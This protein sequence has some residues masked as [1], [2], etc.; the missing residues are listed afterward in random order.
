MTNLAVGKMAVQ[1]S[2]VTPASRATDGSTRTDLKGHSC[3]RTRSQ[4]NPW[5]QVDLTADYEI[6]EVVITNRGDCCGEYDHRYYVL[7][8]F[9]VRTLLLT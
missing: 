7:S 9:R 1:S 4:I 5:L 2:T 8:L 3:A 6:V